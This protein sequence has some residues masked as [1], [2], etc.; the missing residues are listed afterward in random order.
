M[1]EGERPSRKTPALVGLPITRKGILAA[2]GGRAIGRVPA[3]TPDYR[4]L[5]SEFAQRHRNAGA[6]G[7]NR[8]RD[9]AGDSHDEG[10]D[11]SAYQ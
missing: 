1:S 9:S 10:E 2:L 5:G 8:G 3:L 11:D 7:A 4:L 6:G